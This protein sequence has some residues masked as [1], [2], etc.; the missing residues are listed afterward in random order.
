LSTSLFSTLGAV[1]SA[2]K[3]IQAIGRDKLIGILSPLS[4]GR[5]KDNEPIYAIL[6]TSFAL[7]GIIFFTSEINEIAPFISQF[8]LLTFGMLIFLLTYL[9]RYSES[10]M[11]S[12][13]SLGE[14]QLS[15]KFPVF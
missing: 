13:S 11:R 7:L 2:A 3:V 5:K 15:T 4:F 6:L 14:H 12:S 1:I 10:C 9:T 8:A